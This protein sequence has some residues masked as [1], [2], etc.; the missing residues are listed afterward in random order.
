ML[1]IFNCSLRSFRENIK[2]KRLYMWGGGN[3]AE[4]CYKEWGIK[5]NIAAI[6]DNN[7][8][9]WNRG[10]CVDKKIVCINKEKLVTDINKHGVK[11]CV[12]LITSVFYAMDII[13]ELDKIDSLNE[14]ETYIASLLSEYYISQ[15]FEFTKGIQRIPKKIHYCWFG[16]KE[17]PDRLQEYIETWRQFCPE[18]DLIRWDES[19]YDI[20]KN[21]YMYEAYCAGKYGFVPDYARL[22]I[23]YNYGGIYLDT[24]V[25]LCRNFDAL[26][27]DDSFFSV[28]F[29]ECVNAGSGFGAICHNPIVG[30][31]KKAYENEHFINK[32]GSLNLKPCH[33]YQNP[34]LKKFGFEITQRYQKIDGNVLYPCEVLSPIATYSGAERITEKTHSIHRAELSWISEGEREARNRFKDRIGCRINKNCDPLVWENEN[35]LC[36]IWSRL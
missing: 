13:E 3:R 30:E 28:D 27:C 34:V 35:E 18:Y 31:M 33:H 22:D 2:E 4:L 32:D 9:M 1:Q 24:D 19:N 20:T 10:W 29:E 26:L 25:E 8:K 14:L 5:E 6:V 17:I 16:G 15:D 23:I 11:N 7:E 12:L 21:S 36:D